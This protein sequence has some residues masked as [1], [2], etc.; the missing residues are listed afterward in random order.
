[1]MMM[2]QIIY[3]SI[4]FCRLPNLTRFQPVLNIYFILGGCPNMT[5]GN[6]VD[7]IMHVFSNK[8][9][10]VIINFRQMLMIGLEL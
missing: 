1:M 2:M 10:V 9:A 6:T 5:F 3:S 4:R 8:L 7:D